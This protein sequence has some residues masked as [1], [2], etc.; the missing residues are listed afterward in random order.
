M[1]TPRNAIDFRQRQGIGVEGWCLG[2]CVYSALLCYYLS[3][4]FL[5]SDIASSLYVSLEYS[6]SPTNAL[7]NAQSNWESQEGSRHLPVLSTD[8]HG[9]HWPPPL[10][11]IITNASDWCWALRLGGMTQWTWGSLWVDLLDLPP[12]LLLSITIPERE[13]VISWMKVVLIVQFFIL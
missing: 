10:P 6:L 2:A 5:K 8:S 1:V 13:L 3:C 4:V 9:H 12:F 11:P 7:K